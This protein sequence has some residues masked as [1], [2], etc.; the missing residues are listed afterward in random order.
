MDIKNLVC[1][2]SSLALIFACLSRSSE[3]YQFIVGGKDGWVL[4][5]SESYSQWAGRNRFSVN[6]TLLFR[7]PKGSDSVLVVSK[8]DYDN[9]NTANPILKLD[10]GNSIFRYDRSGPFYFITGTK[11]NCDKGQKLVTVVMAVRSTPTP[12]TT[13]APPPLS[14][15]SPPVISPSYPPSVTSPSPAASPANQAP[16]ASP[17]AS[18]PE[19]NLSPPSTTTPG[20]PG[21][22]VPGGGNT[23]SGGNQPSGPASFVVRSCSPKVVV[24]LAVSAVFGY[25]ISP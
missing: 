7:Y 3:A 12:P 6:D 9:C 20:S 19:A 4:S 23:P 17:P 2:F 25:I 5:P 1:V 16:G 21:A 13:A 24:V 22:P 10:D 11:E 8:D 14:P 15:S 18:S